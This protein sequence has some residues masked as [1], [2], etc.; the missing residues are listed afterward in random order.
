MGLASFDLSDI[1]IV[2]IACFIPLCYAA[3][4][5]IWR[6]Y[7]S[8]IAQFPGPKLAALTYWYEFYFDCIQRST[9]PWEINRMH[10]VYGMRISHLNFRYYPSTNN[11]KAQLYGST[12]TSSM[13]KI[14]SGSTN[15]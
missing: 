4:V 8:P 5:A 2:V 6:L 11:S 7:F 12:L 1:H 15:S 3:T 14:P 10:K 9:Y 13:S